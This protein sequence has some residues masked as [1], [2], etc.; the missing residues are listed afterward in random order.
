MMF[1]INP[2]SKIWASGGMADAPVLGTGLLGGE[3][4]SPF[5]PTKKV[6]DKSVYEVVYDTTTLSTI[7]KKKGVVYNKKLLGSGLRKNCTF[8]FNNTSDYYS[9]SSKCF[10]INNLIYTYVVF[11][12]TSSIYASR[13]PDVSTSNY[14]VFAQCPIR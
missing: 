3:G 6:V 5:S 1:A 7:E 4:S 2:Q 9:I 13:Q 8:H 14:G 11:L 10:F 12:S